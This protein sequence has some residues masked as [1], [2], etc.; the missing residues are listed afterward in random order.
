MTTAQQRL[1]RAAAEQTAELIAAKRARQE[2]FITDPNMKNIG[3]V[4]LKPGQTSIVLTADEA[5]AFIGQGL[6]TVSPDER[7][8]Q[9]EAEE[10]ADAEH[11]EKHAEREARRIEQA[12]QNAKKAR[13]S[14]SKPASGGDAPA[15]S[16]DPA[17]PVPAAGDAPASTQAARAAS[18]RQ[19]R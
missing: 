6:D 10:T 8:K 16:K 2:Y 3:N 14:A 12:E 18:G 11:R 4:R 7:A 13:S 17:P 5:K 1:N 19:G 9:R 15:P